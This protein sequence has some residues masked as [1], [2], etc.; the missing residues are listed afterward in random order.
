MAAID[1]EQTGSAAELARL[2]GQ[3]QT[4]IERRSKGTQIDI[5]D[6]TQIDVKMNMQEQQLFERI[7]GMV[8][9]ANAQMMR[10]VEAEINAQ[11]KQQIQDDTDQMRNQIAAQNAE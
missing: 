9:D 3:N 2:S 1:K 4:D 6:R 7:F 10:R 5:V 8:Q 11:T